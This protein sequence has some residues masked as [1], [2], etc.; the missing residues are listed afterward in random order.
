ML[1]T[2]YFT[3]CFM[4]LNFEI[5]NKINETKTEISG[6]ADQE[7]QEKKDKRSDKTPKTKQRLVN[8][9]MAY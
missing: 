7:T 2:S 4:S 8:V 5:K 1:N 9:I 6:H 3:V